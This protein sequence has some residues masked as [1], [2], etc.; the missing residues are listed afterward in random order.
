MGESLALLSIA[1]RTGLFI[2]VSS[3]ALSISA[4]LS[5]GEPTNYF[6]REMRIDAKQHLLPVGQKLPRHFDDGSYYMFFH[7]ANL[8]WVSHLLA[9]G[10]TGEQRQLLYLETDKDDLLERTVK[11]DRIIAGRFGAVVT[12]RTC[13]FNRP[14]ETYPSALLVLVQSMKYDEAEI[15]NAMPDA[16]KNAPPLTSFAVVRF[17]HEGSQLA[18]G[19][20]NYEATGAIGA[21]QSG[22][23][24]NGDLLPGSSTTF[25]QAP[26]FN[27]LQHTYGLSP[28]VNIADYL[29]SNRIALATTSDAEDRSFVV[30]VYGFGKL[31]R[32][33]SLG[34]GGVVASSR[35]YMPLVTEEEK[36]LGAECDDRFRKQQVAGESTVL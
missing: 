24:S 17:F 7:A 15:P 18:F 29:R 21:I 16:P 11:T 35:L 8:T 30:L 14:I 6:V 20:G 36:T 23:T 12:E 27:N 33:D 1:R 13:F 19:S 22:K 26:E 4:C 2:A 5:I 28:R 31:I 10:P 3:S 32:E 25:S 9:V 34:K